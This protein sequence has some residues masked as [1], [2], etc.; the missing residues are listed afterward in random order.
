MA[1]P[2]TSCTC[3]GC[4]RRNKAHGLCEGHYQRWRKYGEGF[5]RSPV[6]RSTPPGI[7]NIDGCDR[8][9]RNDGLCPM[10]YA[11]RESTGDPLHVKKVNSYP[12][13]FRF[14]NE[15]GY[16]HVRVAS[17][18]RRGWKLEHRLVMERAIGRELRREETVHHKNGIR[19]DNR[20]EN[21]ELWASIHPPGQ[22]VADLVEF[23]RRVLSLYS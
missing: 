16:I 17:G 11:R 18:G 13:G 21:L 23:A 19:S 10:H 5:D 22:R 20:I 8:K 15:N 2:V 6:R 7:C 9:R 1:R 3:P 12:V 4:G 14:E